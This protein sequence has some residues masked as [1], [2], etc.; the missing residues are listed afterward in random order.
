MTPESDI[1]SR[2][3]KIRVAAFDLDGTLLDSS[4]GLSVGNRAALERAAAA[5]VEIVPATGRFWNGIPECVRTLPFVRYAITMNGAQVW[6]AVASRT[7]ARSE[8]PLALALE[9][10]RFADGFDAIYD[11]Y[12]DGRGWMT[13]SMLARA[14]EFAPTE[15]YL[16]MIRETRDPVPDLKEDA[17]AAGHDIQKLVVWARKGTSSAQ[18]REAFA[19]RFPGLCFSASTP[20][21]LEINV[22]GTDKG[23]ALASLCVYLG[24][25]PAQTLAAGDGLNDLPLVRAAGVGVAMANAA[26]EVRAAADWI[27]PS[28]DEDGVAAALAAFVFRRTRG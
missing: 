25:D 9:A 7:V 26:P 19:A 12:R 21:N 2:R 18:I 23:R 22:A 28:N 3:R 20:N 10:M 24:I 4:M 11:C 14:G 1:A 16:R 8:I 6:D 15:R 27:A 13:A 5:G 17:A